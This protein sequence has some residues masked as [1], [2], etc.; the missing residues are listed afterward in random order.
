MKN[1]YQIIMVILVVALSMV[2]V[3]SIMVFYL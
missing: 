2:A 3:T 1:K